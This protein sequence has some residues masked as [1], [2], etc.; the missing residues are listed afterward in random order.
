[1]TGVQ[2]CA[3]PISN[4]VSTLAVSRTLLANSNFASDQIHLYGP[5]G[6]LYV[7]ELTTEDGSRTITTEDGSIILLG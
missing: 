7:P 5:I 4:V 3:L 1:M 2:T 6:V